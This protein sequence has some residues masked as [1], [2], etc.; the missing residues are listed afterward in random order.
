MRPETI[1]SGEE[2]FDRV[3]AIVL[4]QTKLVSPKFSLVYSIYFCQLILTVC[5]SVH[6]RIL[7][8]IISA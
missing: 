6:D 5:M 8:S 1:P 4:G 7:F 3:S 2:K